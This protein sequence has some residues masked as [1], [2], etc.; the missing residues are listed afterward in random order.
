MYFPEALA[1]RLGHD[2]PVTFYSACEQN[3]TCVNVLQRT[4]APEHIFSDLCNIVS[5]EALAL[6]QRMQQQIARDASQSSDY[7]RF[8]DSS[9]AGD[10]FL[11]AG[12]YYLRACLNQDISA[13]TSYCHTHGKHCQ[14]LPDMRQARAEKKRRV[15]WVEVGGNTCTPWS[16]NFGDSVEFGR[17]RG[18][19]GN[20]GKIQGNSVEFSG[21]LYGA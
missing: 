16:G 5:A 3:Q 9:E 11:Q 21:V 13:L 17:F 19:S 18:N 8:N 6:V 1:D 10:A 4:L 14:L 7:C 20:F 2:I 15:L 12:F